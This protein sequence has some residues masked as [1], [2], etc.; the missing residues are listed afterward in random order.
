MSARAV[1]SASREREGSLGGHVRLDGKQISAFSRPY[2]TVVSFNT[3]GGWQ[4]RRVDRDRTPIRQIL[5]FKIQDAKRKAA[6]K[7][8]RVMPKGM[9]DRALEKKYL[10]IMGKDGVIERVM[11]G[12][13]DA[14]IG[15]ATRV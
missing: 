9:Q 13:D 2:S 14:A 10:E 5:A 7:W 12:R 1:C 6:V 8:L 3:A 4:V 15:E 11:P